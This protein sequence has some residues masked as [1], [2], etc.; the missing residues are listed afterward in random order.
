MENRIGE[1]KDV[2]E[3]IVYIRSRYGDFHKL[4]P[5]DGMD[6][7]V[8]RLVSAEDWMPVQCSYDGTFGN[9]VEEKELLSVDPDGGPYMTQGF[10]VVGILNANLFKKEIK[11]IFYKKGNGFLL[12]F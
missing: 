8:R 1:M 11:R 7:N 3:N 6:E 4:V 12:Q 2:K 10:V 9:D 5:V